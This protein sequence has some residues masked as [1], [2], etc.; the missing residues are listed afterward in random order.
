[1]KLAFLSDIHGNLPALEICLDAVRALGCERIVCLGDTFGYFQ[2]GTA[3]FDMLRQAGAEVMLGNHEAML[4]RRIQTTPE[5]ELVYQLDAE[6]SR[7]GSQVRNEL[8][9]LLPFREIL[10]GKRRIL[11]VHG[12]PW[13]PLSGYVFPDTDLAP[14]A[15]LP[16]DGIFMGHTHRPFVRTEANMRVVNVGSCGLPRDVGSMAC[17]AVYDSESG[18]VELIRPGLDTELIRRTYPSA[19]PAVL[20]VLDRR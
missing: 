12:A 15:A 18:H 7:L 2:D 6:R 16:Y 14:L 3:C 4:L 1:M 9:R 10:L 13:D 11:M 19:H 20:A 17:F 5:R 8:K